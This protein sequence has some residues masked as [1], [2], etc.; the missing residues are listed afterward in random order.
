[1]LFNDSVSGTGS[2]SN[3]VFSDNAVE[4]KKLAKYFLWLNDNFN[5]LTPS[6]KNDYNILKVKQNFSIL[7]NKPAAQLSKEER[8]FLSQYGVSSPGSTSTNA[9]D[10]YMESLND[11][12]ANI[13][14]VTSKDDLP[15]TNTTSKI[16]SLTKAGKNYGF[17]KAQDVYRYENYSSGET[18][19]YYV[20]KDINRYEASGGTTDN[21]ISRYQKISEI[22]SPEP[23]TKTINISGGGGGGTSSIGK[24]TPAK[25]VKL[26]YSQDYKTV[27]D[28]EIN[29]QVLELLNVP[30]MVLSQYDWETID[31]M[32]DTNGT[33]V[34]ENDEVIYTEYQE[35]EVKI[36]STIPP[37]VAN[38]V[39]KI[40]EN[41]SPIHDSLNNYI[42]NAIT[43]LLN[44][45]FH[46]AKGADL[47]A[48][49]PAYRAGGEPRYD[50][51]V[52][53]VDIDGVLGYN[54]YL[55]EEDGII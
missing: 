13:Q 27:Y 5:A 17:K 55:V 23:E 42:S 8:A 2:F 18:T 19:Y 25:Y 49:F 50:F 9:M 41:L 32:S 29:K 1:M 22:V 30:D 16:T 6:Q 15:T 11:S 14:F 51:E 33:V 47:T 28:N 20:I 44:F 43:R 40:Q 38:L 34:R 46:K 37:E 45:G 52:D 21:I 24:T 54:I 4:E 48:I 26:W 10:A 7:K 31:S 12:S 39:Y 36:Q 3:N 35:P 53:F